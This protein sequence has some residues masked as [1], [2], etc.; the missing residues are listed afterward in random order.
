[1]SLMSLDFFAFFSVLFVAYWLARNRLAQNL[2]LLV[3]S[4]LFYGWFSP[5][6][7]VFLGL[8]TLAD[9]LLALQINRNRSRKGL[10]LALSL[11]LNLG[12]LLGFKYYDFFSENIIALFNELG[13]APGWV[14]TSVIL[15]AGVSFY[16]LKKLAYVLDVSRGA[17]SPTHNPVTFGL[18]VSFFPQVLS[19]PIDRPQKLFPQIESR[20]S[21][22]AEYFYAA[23][24]LLVMGL[25]KKIVVASSVN[26]INARIFGLSEVPCFLLSVA[27]LGFAVEI[28]ADFSAYTDLSRGLALLLGFETPENFRQ[29]YLALTPAEFWNRWHI[30]LSQWLRDYI[31]FPT[32]RFMLRHAAQ[33]PDWLVQFIPPV[34]TML[35][36]GLW[37]GTGWTFL[38]WGLYHGILLGAYQLAGIRA[39]WKPAGWKRLAAWGVMFFFTLFG[40]IIFRAT[41]LTWLWQNLT[42]ASLLG[43]SNHIAIALL[44]LTVIGFY[45]APLLLKLLLDRLTPRGH[46]LQSVFYAVATIMTIF[47][48]N[49]A[50]PDFI[51]FQF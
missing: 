14:L 10:W 45:A 8:S 9:F 5:W 2:V 11:A 32:R 22:K 49:S 21:W 39:D 35:V 27:A 28:L 37:H 36:S 19:G 26:A 13:L 16:T 6:F 29:P 38:A 24:P 17:L 40:W 20:R 41:S 7:A 43:T 1:M 12:A 31:F 15:P 50:T 51:Y 46:I 4:Y 23:W 18:Y 42:T 3:G 30:T 33:F 48:I 34:I 25:F 47:Y 44:S